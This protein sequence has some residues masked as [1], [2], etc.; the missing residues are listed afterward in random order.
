MSGPV[1]LIGQFTIDDADRYRDYALDFSPI[2]KA[3]G[4]EIVTYDDNVT[5]LEGERVSG[6]TVI[7]RFESEEACLTWW[8][9][10]EY[11]EIAEHRRAATTTTLISMVHA[12]PSP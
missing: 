5:L 4:G 3:H 10:P 2:L 9:S 12:A 11:Q 6:R 7:I 8:N 1:H